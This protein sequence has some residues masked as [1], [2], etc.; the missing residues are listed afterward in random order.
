MALCGRGKKPLNSCLFVNIDYLGE[1]K[2]LF[3]CLSVPGSWWALQEK[4]ERQDNRHL[5]LPPSPSP[6]T[7]NLPPSPSPSPTISHH[8]HLQGA[9][10]TPGI[11]LGAADVL[12]TT[13]PFPAAAVR[14]QH[15]WGSAPSQPPQT[16][17]TSNSTLWSQPRC[18]HPWNNTPELLQLRGGLGQTG[19][20]CMP[21]T[22]HHLGENK[23]QYF[24]L[25]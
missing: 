14:L 18:K 8:L 15:S 4:E 9:G 3:F 20:C 11:S 23:R 22:R 16:E 6:T 24:L 21:S 10:G 13:E 25:G 2:M 19:R 17:S 12:C 1:R 5:H 7:S